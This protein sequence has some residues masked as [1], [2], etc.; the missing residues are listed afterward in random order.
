MNNVD[1]ANSYATAEHKSLKFWLRNI[2]LPC[3]PKG[4]IQ[5]QFKIYFN[6]KIW[7]F[8]F[9]HSEVYQGLNFKCLWVLDLHYLPSILWILNMIQLGRNTFSKFADV[10][11]VIVF[12]T[13]KVTYNYKYN[14][15]SYFAMK[16]LWPFYL[17]INKIFS[18]FSRLFRA[19]EA[20][21]MSISWQLLTYNILGVLQFTGSINGHAFNS[22]WGAESLA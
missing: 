21:V 12:G 8:Q 22:L 10:N 1:F 13:L 18:V 3:H 2:S 4:P 9:W 19:L 20:C 7:I 15:K 17:F 11:F 5:T 6:S 16:I 14:V